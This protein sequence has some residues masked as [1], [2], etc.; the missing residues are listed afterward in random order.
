MLVPEVERVPK[1]QYKR[2][3]QAYWER[4]KEN[5]V[6]YNQQGA[7]EDSRTGSVRG[8]RKKEN[9]KACCVIGK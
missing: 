3:A 6:S 7:V 8:Y 1:G 2:M 4:Q 5:Q 9:L